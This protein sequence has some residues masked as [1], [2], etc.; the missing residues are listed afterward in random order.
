M[1]RGSKA[2]DKATRTCGSSILLPH[3]TNALFRIRDKKETG[4]I[5]CWQT[6][7]SLSSA[8]QQIH[9]ECQFYDRDR[10][11]KKLN[12]ATAKKQKARVSVVELKRPAP[13]FSKIAQTKFSKEEPGYHRSFDL[14]LHR[15]PGSGG[16][17]NI[18]NSYEQG[19]CEHAATQQNQRSLL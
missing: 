4:R 8:N 1:R 11:V 5:R 16:I 17:P 14:N 15:N 10:V 13:R 9:S 12:L 7:R 6:M 2:G 18:T 3:Y 19:W